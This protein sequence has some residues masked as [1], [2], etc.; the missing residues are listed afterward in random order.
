MDIL[1]SNNGSK[2]NSFE[3]F[4]KYQKEHEDVNIIYAVHLNPAVRETAFRLLGSNPRVHLIDPLDVQDMH[5]LMDRSYLVMTDSGGLQEEA[6]SL[7]K[8][9]LVLRKETER[10]EAVTA[11]T[12]R[13]AGTNRENIKALASQL[14]DHAD[15]YAAMAKAVN[16]YGDGSASERIVNALLYEFGINGNK[17]VEFK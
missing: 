17:P 6:P 8:P 1:L 7:G 12:V 4:K 15:E 10:P 9:V 5:N 13:L 14:L 3:I 11:G 16:P 2:D